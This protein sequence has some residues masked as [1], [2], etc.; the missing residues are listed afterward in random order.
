[1][2]AFSLPPSVA[3]CM[4]LAPLISSVALGTLPSA[5]ADSLGDIKQ[6]KVVKIGVFQDYPPFGSIGA[7]M[8]P[9]GIDVDLAAVLAKKLGAR[10]E[11]VPVTG[12]NRL[13][14]LAD[15][16]VDLLMSVG[17]T[18]ARDKVLD[19]TQAYA[20][21]YIAVFGPKTVEIKQAADLGGKSVAT[22]GGTNEDI[23]LTK[24]AP[25][26]TTIKRFD[27]QSGAISAYLAGQTQLI[28]LGGDVAARVRAMH[29]QTSMDEKIRLL[30]SPMHIAVNKGDGPLRDE[31]NTA[32]DDARKDGSIDQIEKKWLGASVPA[33]SF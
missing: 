11:L 5:Y 6:N 4:A 14:Y 21:Y 31:L 10:A 3:R 8:K 13:A 28:S 15:H 30:D 18:P 20:P 12:T 23:S 22:A 1:M 25:G 24:V 33:S 29:P 26:N 7:D 16:K 17:Q 19:F 9:R 27:D 32:L 2:K